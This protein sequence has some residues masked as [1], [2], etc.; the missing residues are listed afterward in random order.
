VVVARRNGYGA[1]FRGL[2]TLQEGDRVVVTTTQGQAV[3]AVS[4][5]TTATIDGETVSTSSSSTSTSTSSDFACPRSHS[6][7]GSELA[8]TGAS[9]TTTPSSTSTTASGETTT[10]AEA[11]SSTTTTPAATSQS[12]AYTAA[13]TSTSSKSSSVTVD[14]LY[15]PTND[16]RLTLVTSGSKMPWNTS[17]A[18]VVLAKLLGKPYPPTPQGA[19]SADETG[20]A[21]DSGAWAAVVLAMLAFIGVIV[22]SVALYRR[23]RFRVAYVLTIAPLVAFTV[24]AGETLARLLP[25]WT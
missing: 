9:T 24:I 15:G 23:M 19:R 2:D 22:A 7:T 6:K 4:C 16:D 21:S 8:G 14:T 12:S 17:K 1:T 10:T 13:A 20:F 11:T 5:V 18:T 25:A 3:Y